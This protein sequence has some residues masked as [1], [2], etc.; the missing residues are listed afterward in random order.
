MALLRAPSE[1]DYQSVRNYMRNTKAIVR[2]EA[3]FVRRKGDSVYLSNVSPEPRETIDAL[4]ERMIS[5]VDRFFQ[6]TLSFGG[7]R[8]WSMCTMFIRDSTEKSC[9]SDCSQTQS[10]GARPPTATYTTTQARVSAQS[11]VLSSGQLHYC[12]SALQSYA[13][14]HLRSQ[15]THHL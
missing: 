1:N 12:Y 7:V 4:G 15:H 5:A 10:S 11:A 6:R 13:L 8:V 14:R 3:Q 9:D 2:R